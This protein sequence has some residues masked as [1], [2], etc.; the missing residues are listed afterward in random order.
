MTSLISLLLASSLSFGSPVNYPLSL[1]GNFGEPR[2]NHFHCGIDVRTGQVEGKPI[3]SV[4]DGYVSRITVGLHGFGN[5]LYVRHPNG[6]TSVYC[7]LKKFTPQLAAFVRAW[8]YR[9]KRNYADVILRPTD[10]PVAQGQLIAVSGNTGA[11]K[12]PHLHLEFHETKTGNY[13]D[14][15]DYLKDFIDDRTK[16]IAHSFM[17]Y[18]VKGYGLFCGSSNKQTY[19][20]S[21]L[22]LNRRFTAWGKVGF[23]VWGNDYMDGSFGILGVR[24]LTLEVDGKVVFES[25]VDD[26]PAGHNLMVNSWGDYDHYCRTRLWYMKSFADPGNKLPVLTYD[27]NR[28]YVMFTE[29]RDYKLVYTLSDIFGNIRSY[30]FTVRG[31]R[32]TIPPKSNPY[33]T[34]LLRYDR[35]N[36]F[37]RPGVS[38]LL[39]PGLLPDDVSLYP[40]RRT[41]AE[42]YS[43][44]WSFYN[45]SYPLLGWA[46]ISLKLNKKV[47]D[48]D[49]LYIIC[50]YGS[51]RY[52]GGTYQD[53]WVTGK[54]RELGATYEIG[55]DDTPPQMSNISIVGNV[56]RLGLSD[57][58][59]GV[60]NLEGYVDGQFVLFER[61]D[62][63]NIYVCR[64]KETPVV[65]LRK[66]RCLRLVAED[67]LKNRAVVTREIMY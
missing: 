12:A 41:G 39:N 2:P 9:N 63:T 60:K 56:I 46:K 30:S 24:H 32:Q 19:G 54:M 4:A 15:L 21:S 14:P 13:I 27:D 34:R 38:L 3:F 37:Q 10:Y 53:G 23:G 29:E 11:S 28:G 22:N 57:S 5:A 25:N 64:L 26:I 40:I 45:K 42:G 1:A 44:K 36:V 7:H 20:F 48:T 65:E 35:F 59:S 18:P 52:M 51:N 67:N 50:N 33:V 58:G 16:P 47:R 55:Y 17:A 62:K 61:V 8:Q 49:K 31:Q 6:V 66:I 43:D